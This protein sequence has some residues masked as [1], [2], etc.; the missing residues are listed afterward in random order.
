MINNI[1]TILSLLILLIV[2]T[3]AA[4][5]RPNIL[6]IVS[7]DHGWGDLPSNWDKTEVQ[8]P[9]LDT[10]AAKGV[11]FPNYHLSLIHI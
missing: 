4:A 5:D 11:R 10:L 8:L 2:T 7:D 1:R 3:G 6:F 9:T